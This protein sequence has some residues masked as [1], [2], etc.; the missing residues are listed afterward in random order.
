MQ[1]GQ[2]HTHTLVKKPFQ[3]RPGWSSRTGSGSRRS[4]VTHH[5]PLGG[6]LAVAVDGGHLGGAAHHVLNK[7]EVAGGEV[8]LQQGQ[9][10][11]A[12]ER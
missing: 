11:G 3:T 4:A 5:R 1:C 7:L 2:D 10:M 12:R 6:A 8:G 9:G